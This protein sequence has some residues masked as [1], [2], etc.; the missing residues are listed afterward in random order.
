MSFSKFVFVVL[1]VFFAVS[2]DLGH[3]AFRTRLSHCDSFLAGLTHDHAQQLLQEMADAEFFEGNALQ[4]E[5]QDGVMLARTKNSYYAIDFE[6]PQY[7]A[8][9]WLERG[10]LTFILHLK[11]KDSD[12]ER[13]AATPNR[14]KVLRGRAQVYKVF[15]HFRGHRGVRKLSDT[16]VEGSDTFAR[17]EKLVREGEE[18]SSAVWKVFM[19]KM[20]AELGF[21]QAQLNYEADERSVSVIF[22]RK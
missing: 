20:A 17:F 4:F 9:A 14:S 15:N 1:F 19:G 21:G 22:S 11:E 18:P 12:V 16:W 3:A 5:H 7:Y 6:Q 8:F 10:E 2:V 13:G